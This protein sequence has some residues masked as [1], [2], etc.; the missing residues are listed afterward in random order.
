[1]ATDEL[2]SISYTCGGS[3]STVLVAERYLR[4]ARTTGTSSAPSICKL[5]F[6]N[7]SLYSQIFDNNYSNNGRC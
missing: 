1:M 6:Q 4:G 2:T 7:I 5:T 3:K